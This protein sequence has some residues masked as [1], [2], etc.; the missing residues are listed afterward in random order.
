MKKEVRDMM[1]FQPSVPFKD[2]RFTHGILSYFEPGTTVLKKG[3][4]LDSRF[5]PLECDI[6]FEK[7]CTSENERRRYDLYRYLSPGY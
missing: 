6:I 2:D 5:K 7:G 4:Q 1:L 3:W